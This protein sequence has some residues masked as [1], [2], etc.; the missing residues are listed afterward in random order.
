MSTHFQSLCFGALCVY[1]YYMYVF[2]LY[3]IHKSHSTAASSFA[4]SGARNARTASM[5][6]RA[7]E[8]L[9]LPLLLA[10]PLPPPCCVE[11]CSCRATAA[12]KHVLATARPI[13]CG[14]L[15]G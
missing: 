4:R 14:V 10:L 3:T 7:V 12:G 5:N 1:I 9:S 11:G 6:A 8:S 13:S 15:A 2:F